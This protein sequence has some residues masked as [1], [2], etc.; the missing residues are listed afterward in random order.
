MVEK[1]LQ[2]ALQRVNLLHFCPVS[3][4]ARVGFIFLA[5]S[6]FGIC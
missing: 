4:D 2:K 5:V 3:K 6:K 1:V